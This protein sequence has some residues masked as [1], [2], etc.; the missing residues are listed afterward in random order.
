MLGPSVPFSRVGQPII[1]RHVVDVLDLT[2]GRGR[3]GGNFTVMFDFDF[4]SALANLSKLSSGVPDSTGSG[5][6][7]PDL[8]RV[9]VLSCLS[10]V[11]DRDSGSLS[12]SNI[13]SLEILTWRF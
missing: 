4:Q 2:E 12:T 13:P 1:Q 9:K 11:R 5:F 10:S 8:G 7:M 3:G 6:S